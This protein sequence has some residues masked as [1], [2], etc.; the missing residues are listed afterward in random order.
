MRPPN[1]R[2]LVMAVILV[3][4]AL[5]ASACGTVEPESL[6]FA[7]DESERTVIRF[8]TPRIDGFEAAIDEWEREHPTVEV[9]VVLDDLDKHHEWLL[10]GSP[11]PDRIDVVA[12]DGAYSADARE[13]SETFVDLSDYVGE[14]DANSFLSA[15]WAEGVAAGGALIGMPLDTDIALLFVRRD[16]A[17]VTILNDLRNA[18]TWCD[19]IGAGNDLVELTDK[20]FLADGEELLRSILTQNRSSWVESDGQLDKSTVG[21]L[22]RAWNIALQGVGAPTV[23]TNPCPHLGETQPILRDLTPGET[24]WQTELA[25][26]DFGAVI[27]NWSTRALIPRAYPESVDLWAA[28]ELPVD[29]TFS[30]TS[31]SSSEGGLH[32]A[33]P[34]GTSNVDIAVDFVLTLTSHGVQVSTFLDGQG[35]LPAAR[36]A[37]ED[38]VVEQAEDSFFTGTPSIGTVASGTAVGRSASLAEPERQVVIGVLVD[39]LASVQSQLQTSDEA[40]ETALGNIEFLLFSG[41]SAN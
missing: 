39:A 16:M 23:G 19:V 1:E 5:V 35:P 38:G 3:V 8:A 13:R 40:W 14:D 22:Q 12:F 30:A 26:D 37:F 34:A 17:S 15:R 10:E 29:R 9:Q 36:A 28:V 11:P 7:A 21:E 2:T 33:V 41:D 27:S 4:A 6:A 24:I 31:G 18:Q 25:S 20:A 32:L